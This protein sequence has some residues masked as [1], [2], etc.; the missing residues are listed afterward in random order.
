MRRCSTCVMPE[1]TPGIVFDHN[2]V[3]NY[4]ATYQKFDYKGEQKLLK[5]LNAHRNKNNRYDC[6][7]NISG[8]R[9]SAYTLLMLVKE[10]Q[11]KV[12][13]VNYE[14][15][16]TDIQA[17]INIQNMVKALKIDIVQF[18]LKNRIHE[19]CLR[20][21]LLA[22]FRHPSAAMVPVVC[23]GC[24]I[25]WPDIIRIARKYNIH[26][27][28]NGGNPFE[29]TSFKKELLSVPRDASLKSTYR[30]NIR[31]LLREALKNISYLNPIL[32][33]ATLKGYLFENQYAI[34]SRL[35]A[36]NI[37]RID[38]FHYIPWN[39]DEILSRIR[40]ELNWDSPSN[41]NSTWRFDCQ[42]SHLKDFMYMKTL[43]ITERDDFYSKMIREG[44]IT[45]EYALSRLKN[46]N[47]L[48][49]DIIEEILSRL[50]IEKLHL[51]T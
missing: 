48:H 21:N 14:N 31:G 34:G 1:S 20:N 40:S 32:L 30:K 44:L 28:V 13:A 49:L 41:L 25:I 27:I 42:I 38:F 43:G 8:G 7:V 11:M 26:C 12:L 37:D 9:D 5:I 3:C 2:G 17:K 47:K 36:A 50:G 18:E 10:Y 23:I 4:C 46:E 45:R 15:P 29:Y 33:P 19:R 16:F 24:K 35:L 51:P 22:W 6:I 39:E